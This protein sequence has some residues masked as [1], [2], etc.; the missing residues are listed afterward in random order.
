MVE[1]T[2]ERFYEPEIHRLLGAVAE[3]QG[4]L[5]AA[6]C[7][8]DRAAEVAGELGLVALGRRLPAR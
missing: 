8:D 6:G 2:G 7:H 3:R 1:I 5:Q 4:R